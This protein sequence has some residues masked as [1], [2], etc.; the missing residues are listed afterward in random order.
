MGISYRRKVSRRRV[1]KRDKS[2]VSRHR[3][4]GWKKLSLRSFCVIAGMYEP[5][6]EGTDEGRNQPWSCVGQ[7]AD[8]PP[9]PV[10]RAS[11]FRRRSLRDPADRFPTTPPTT[12]TGFLSNPF[13]ASTSAFLPLP[14]RCRLLLLLVQDSGWSY[15]SY[16]T[17]V[18][19]RIILLDDEKGEKRDTEGW[20][21]ETSSSRTRSPL[22]MCS[23]GER[24]ILIACDIRKWWQ[25]DAE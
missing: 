16:E 14:P 5:R 6:G 1:S 9:Y 17:H 4:S 15:P 23:N 21:G 2:D 19:A 24:L 18:C 7:C 10:A 11:T 25:G 20:R 12:V 8:S 13:F 3:Q 22:Y